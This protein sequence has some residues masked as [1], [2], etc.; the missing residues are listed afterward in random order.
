MN[1]V[2]ARLDMKGEFIGDFLSSG[3]ILQRSDSV[4]TVVGHA[5]QRAIAPFNIHHDAKI[6]CIFTIG[7]GELQAVPLYHGMNFYQ[8]DIA[9]PKSGMV[10]I[11]ER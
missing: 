1:G 11:E 5:S 2:S 3:D 7:G 6:R 8:N 4:K 9:F 10:D